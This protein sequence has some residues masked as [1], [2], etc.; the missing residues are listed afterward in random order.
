MLF[1][2][3]VLDLFFVGSRREVFRGLLLLL[4]L[5]GRRGCG[6]SRHVERQERHRRRR[7]QRLK[8]ELELLLLL[9]LLHRR[10]PGHWRRRRR[11]EGG[12]RGWSRGREPHVLLLV[13]RRAGHRDPEAARGNGQQRRLLLQ[14][15]LLLLDVGRWR[16]RREGDEEGEGRRREERG[17]QLEVKLLLLECRGRGGRIGHV[18]LLLLLEFRSAASVRIGRRLKL[19]QRT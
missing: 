1:Q 9:L 3:T 19:L 16:R 2:D 11:E 12:V 15:R 8:L 6:G 13:R 4:R 7:G 10:L 5:S 18:L 14:L 17:L